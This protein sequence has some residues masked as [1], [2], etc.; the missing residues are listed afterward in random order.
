MSP[1][2]ADLLYWSNPKSRDV[3]SFG[4]ISLYIEV[5]QFTEK[6]SVISANRLIS[7]EEGLGQRFRGSLLIRKVT[8][9]IAKDVIKELE[10]Y[11]W[12]QQVKNE[13]NKYTITF[14]GKQMGELARID[15]KKFRRVL[16]VKMHQRF[17]IPG[18]FVHRLLE[19]NP[20]R[21]GEIVLPGL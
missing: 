15:I 17:T 11:D 4:G 8:P 18:W 12:I 6:E 14:E 20:N 21:Q 1:S 2:L 3:G 19:L 10:A 13:P 5:L 9:T 7:E 16:A